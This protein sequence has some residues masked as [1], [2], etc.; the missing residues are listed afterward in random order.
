MSTYRQGS[1]TMPLPKARQRPILEPRNRDVMTELG[2]AVREY[3]PMLPARMT[4]F[5]IWALAF[6]APWRKTSQ[7][8]AHPGTNRFVANPAW[9]GA[10]QRRERPPGSAS[11]LRIRRHR[12]AIAA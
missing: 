12:R 4:P 8:A 7:P 6:E 11:S 9:G 10:S 1:A 3:L 5:L 2:E